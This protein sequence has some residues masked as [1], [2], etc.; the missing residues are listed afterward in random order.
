MLKALG[1]F[2]QSGGGGG[3]PDPLNINDLIAANVTIN[4]SLTANLAASNT[5]AMPDPSLPL[6]PE[7]YISV[8][9][10]GS[11]KKIPYYGV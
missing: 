11:T 10:N 8:V 2:V 7:G 6:N 5:A 9:I 1:G 4:N 3:V